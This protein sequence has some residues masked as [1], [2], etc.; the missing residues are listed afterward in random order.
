M[1]ENFVAIKVLKLFFN[2]AYV[3][4]SPQQIV[5]L[6]KK[7]EFKISYFDTCQ[8]QQRTYFSGH[9]KTFFT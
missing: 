4:M 8:M 7:L 1:C 6:L 9:P 5:V 3:K 2:S